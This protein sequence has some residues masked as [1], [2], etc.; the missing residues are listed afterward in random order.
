[1]LTLR[2]AASVAD[3]QEGSCAP[4]WAIFFLSI[5]VAW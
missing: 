2:L 1:M 3:G 4:K 5:S